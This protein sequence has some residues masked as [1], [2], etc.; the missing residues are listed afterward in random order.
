MNRFGVLFCEACRARLNLSAEKPGLETAP[1]GRRRIAAYLLLSVLFFTTGVGVLAFWPMGQGYVPGN[2]AA[3]QAFRQKLWTLRNTAEP[4]RQNFAEA[5]INAGLAA[6]L[7][8]FRAPG[9]PWDLRLKAG[10]VSVKPNG[11]IVSYLAQLGPLP[12][13]HYLL[14]PFKLSGRL[15]Y[16][17]VAP[18]KFS[19]RRAWLGHVC[20]P[21][22]LAR[23]AVWPARPFWLAV[24]EQLAP[25]RALAWDIA[26]GM[27]AAQV[28]STSNAE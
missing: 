21:G 23:L 19:L 12:V 28:T 20:L 22:P 11:V 4:V 17:Y 3:L 16:A 25:G 8:R 2:P 5:E 18:G 14:G 13:R 7:S 27:L 10:G 26:D 9:S 6:A 1:S 15:I 24:K